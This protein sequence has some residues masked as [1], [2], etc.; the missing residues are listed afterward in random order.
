MNN[1]FIGF[2]IGLQFTS[3]VGQMILNHDREAQTGEFRNCVCGPKE[4]P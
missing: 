1:L 3:C 4:T 2:V